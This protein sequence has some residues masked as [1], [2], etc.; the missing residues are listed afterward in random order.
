MIR[1]KR[2]K[3][4]KGRPNPIEVF[5]AAQ[6]LIE[7][8]GK[9]ASEVATINSSWHAVKNPEAAHAWRDVIEA[10]KVLEGTERPAGEA[11]N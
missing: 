2:A 7:Q 5:G 6:M 3:R 4:V 10:I 9:D 1:K 8:H 11:L